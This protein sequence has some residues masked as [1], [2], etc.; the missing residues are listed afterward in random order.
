MRLLRGEMGRIGEGG[1][2]EGRGRGVE[3]ERGG[4]IGMRCDEVL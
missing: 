1:V 3:G 4:E 2:G